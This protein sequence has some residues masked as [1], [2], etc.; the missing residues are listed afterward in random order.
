[1]SALQTSQVAQPLGEQTSVTQLDPLTFPLFGSRLIEASAGTGKTFTLALLYVRLILGQ[2]NNQ[3]GFERPLTPKEI[4]VVTFTDL[5]AGELRDRIRARLVDA[6]DYF[7]L[8]E[9]M[10]DALLATLRQD[11]PEPEWPRCAWRLQMAAESM[12]EASVSTIHSWCNRMLVEHTFDTRGLFNRELVTDSSALL[13]EVVEDYWRVHFYRLNSAQAREVLTAFS[14]PSALESALRNLIKPTS[15]G[16][17]FIGQPLQAESPLLEANLQEWANYQTAVEHKLAEVRAAWAD[18]W[19]DIQEHLLALQPGL[20]KSS[21]PAAKFPALLVEIAD[22]LHNQGSE[23]TKLCHFAPG[24]LRIN[25]TAAI[26]QL[27]PWRAFE[28]VGELNAL[29]HADQQPELPINV[30]ILAEATLWVK[31]EFQKRMQQSAQMGFDDLLVQLEQALDPELAGDHAYALAATLRRNFPIAMIDE[32]QDTDPIQFNIFDR[33]Y[34][35]AN[36]ADDQGLFM[37]G[38]PKQ[39]IY[40][41]RGADIHTYLQV[42][43]ATAGRHYT[44]KKN[45]R[46]TQGVVDACNAFFTYAEQQ[47]QAAFRYQ[48]SPDTA[49]PIPFIAVEAQGRAQQLFLNQ[50]SAEQAAVA[51][52]TLWYFADETDNTP[53]SMG[54]FRQ[55]AA[56]V[57]ASQ[58]SEWLNNAALG[59]AGFGEHG[60]EQ[61]LAPAD[62]AIL[63]RTSSEA[64]LITDALN[65]L[66]IP[67]V[68]LSDREALLAS[69]EAAD[70]LHWLRACAEPSDERLVKAALGT[71]TL[72]LSISQLAHW[73]IDELAWEAQM[74][75]FSRWQRIWRRQGVLVMLQRLM[76]HYQLPAR[77]LSQPKGERSL[78]NLLHLGEWL[79]QTASQIDGEHALIRHLHEHLGK[80]D[81][82]LLLRLESDAR[83]V[84]IITIHKSKGLEFPL[85]LLPFISGWRNIDGKQKQVPY[86]RDTGS[87]TEVS[88]NKRFPKAW[89]EANDER[90][91]E[92][93]RLLYVALTRASHALWLG[94]APLGT[95]KNPQLERSALGHVLNGGKKFKDADAVWQALSTLAEHPAISLVSAPEAVNVPA[96]KLAELPLEDARPAPNLGNLSN[97]W[98]ASYSALQFGGQKY[99][100]DQK[101]NLQPNEPTSAQEDQ[102]LELSQTGG[103]DTALASHSTEQQASHDFMHLFPRGPKW[104]TFLHGLLEWAAVA[105]GSTPDTQALTGFIA[106][107]LDDA[108][109]DAM[110][111]SRCK[112]RNIETLA[113]PLS[114]WL[115]DFILQP[116]LSTGF[117]L[118]ELTPQHIAVELEFLIEVHSVNAIALDNLVRPYTVKDAVAPQAK[119]NFLNGMLKG[120]IDLVAEKDGRYYVIDWKSNYLGADDASYSQEN[121]Q[122]A[123]FEHRY[124]VQYLLYILALHRQLTARLP[125]YD[126][127]VHVGGA[128][129]VF[130]RGW[131]APSQGLFHD[132]PPKALIEALDTLFSHSPTLSNTTEGVCL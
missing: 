69:S 7:K 4:L 91:K 85:V 40:S 34:Q 64:A 118:S 97:W 41:F 123:I 109:R 111:A 132:K 16:I 29:R 30:A 23:P 33:I 8:P 42:R 122:K 102:L 9:L 13:T 25:K 115:K 121:M 6:A 72:G 63:V 15:Q 47:P 62:I 113:A 108:G 88:D 90:I 107:A 3:C 52:M 2:G 12:D 114:T 128:V 81:Q 35:V 14:S 95:T 124:D 82:Q 50:A 125:D 84:K 1:M 71:C 20:N 39:S 100:N 59:Q 110:L 18:N 104:G 119:G 24:A 21:F 67:S 101:H 61:V 94:V 96:P 58:I 19:P 37:I 120:F 27:A 77:L 55:R 112:L 53:L 105:R 49:N 5:A 11:Y 46:S 31:N 127:D 89:D 26:Q 78:T 75:Q 93:L 68:F 76:A 126:Y 73:Q 131:Q 70:L 130:L 106:A 10:D 54:L 43:S 83:R 129:Y 79:Q 22:W 32:F 65:K 66:R 17:S 98:I 60:V 48:H 36:T 116:W 80:D 86:H 57:A 92:D 117:A 44:L 38:D 74:Q 56:D 28:L 87:Y 45:F 103:G 51:P 99:D